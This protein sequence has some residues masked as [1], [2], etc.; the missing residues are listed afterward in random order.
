MSPKEDAKENFSKFVHVL[1]LCWLD[2]QPESSSQSEETGI[3][4]KALIEPISL[5]LKELSASP[6][7][8]SGAIIVAY[9]SS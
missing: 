3:H 4:K 9:L 8:N 7:C 2:L 5:H 6:N 1:L